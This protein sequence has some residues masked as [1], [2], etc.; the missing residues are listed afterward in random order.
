MI[1]AV[2]TLFGM[3]KK[4]EPEPRSWERERL[5]MSTDDTVVYAVGDVHGCLKELLAAEDRIVADA[6]KVS[7]KRRVI[8]L[9]GDL[10][11]RG[12]QSADVLDHLTRSAPPGFERMAI[13]GNHDDTFLGFM[14]DPVANE[15][16]LEFGGVETMQSYGMDVE[17]LL[18]QRK[19]LASL[20]AV[21]RETVPER[22]VAY[23]SALPVSVRFG[24][25]LFVHAG[26]RPGV[27]L[28]DQQDEDFMWIREAFLGADHGLGLTVVHGHTPSKDPV[29]VPGRI[30]ID[31]GA[32]ATGRL[33]V[34]RMFHNEAAVIG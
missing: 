4:A 14:E 2:R 11:D 16:W 13:C 17:R 25:T 3:G 30:G 12:P 32:Y 22:H 23:L 27:P 9:L 6:A 19:G 15:G 26:V 24:D 21:L 5:E 33:T 7:A 28:A 18:R 34:L 10:I 29:F 8:L 1:A 20:A 31:T